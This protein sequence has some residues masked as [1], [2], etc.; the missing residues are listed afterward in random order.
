MTKYR[1]NFIPSG[2]FFFTVNLADR[3]Q[4]LL[5][6]NIEA[7]QQAFRT[8]KADQPFDIVAMV[9]LPEHLHTIWTLPPGDADYSTR[10]KRRP[11]SEKTCSS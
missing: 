5:V 2:S 1:R 10:W 11:N 3:S 4:R 9:V 6:E 8:V 7:L